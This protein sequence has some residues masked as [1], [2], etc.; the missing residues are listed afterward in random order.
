MPQRAVFLLAYRLLT[1]SLLLNVGLSTPI[2][3]VEVVS[4]AKNGETTSAVVLP[5]GASKTKT[6]IAP[7]RQIASPV[8]LIEK[9][10]NS[11]LTSSSSSGSTVR[12]VNTDKT[13]TNLA[14]QTSVNGTD[15]VVKLIGMQQPHLF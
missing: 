1:Y 6:N 3:N 9:I 15:Q 10:D 7:E 11:N 8:S 13:T 4:L 5:N 14:N 12:L 2:L